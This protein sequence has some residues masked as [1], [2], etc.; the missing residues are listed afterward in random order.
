MNNQSINQ[1]VLG[2]LTMVAILTSFPAGILLTYPPVE[3]HKDLYTNA[4][5]KF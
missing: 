4:H 1:Q 2:P 3:G 5:I